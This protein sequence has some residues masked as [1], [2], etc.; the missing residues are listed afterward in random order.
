MRT[1]QSPYG[2]TLNKPINGGGNVWKGRRV[3]VF[4]K[5]T[6][7][8]YSSFLFMFVNSG[9]TE[10][11]WFSGT[12]LKH[13]M[14]KE[15]QHEYLVHAVHTHAQTCV[16]IHAPHT[17]VHVRSSHLN[18]HIHTHTHNTPHT[19]HTTRDTAHTAHIQLHASGEI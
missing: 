3:L 10:E 15:G 17:T 8:F 1:Q 19:P 14:T 5:Y 9:E 18:A 7:E 4:C 13:K 11:Q 12:I 16:H 6:I 2:F